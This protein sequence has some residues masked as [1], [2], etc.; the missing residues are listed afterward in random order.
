MWGR[1][2]R[3]VAVTAR[4]IAA[5]GLV[6]A[7]V[8]AA[9]ARAASL[10]SGGVASVTVTGPTT[11]SVTGTVNPGG[12]TTSY[13]VVYGL[14][15]SQWCQT[16][17]ASGQP[18]YS[19]GGG[20]TTGT[21]LHVFVVT[22]SGLT[23]GSTYCVA[24]R[25]TNSLGTVTGTPYRRFTAGAP[26]ARAYSPT[27]TSATTAT[28]YGGVNPAGQTT[29]YQVRYDL[30]GSTWCTSNGASGTATYSTVPQTLAYTDGTLHSVWVTM[31]G[32]TSGTGYCATI[33]A[34]NATASTTGSILTFTLD[35]PGV[36][37]NNV[38]V[39]GATTATITG[40]VNAFSQTN[41]YYRAI[42]DL[43]SSLWC[44][45]GGNVPDATT[46]WGGGIAFPYSDS[47]FHSVSVDLG[48][49]TAGTAY[50]ATL[51]AGTTQAVPIYFTTAPS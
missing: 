13:A 7:F 48:A 5:V 19:G 46:S 42:Y 17:G 43:A 3:A 12:L 4:S 21:S 20:V 30:A 16:Y 8:F 36:V 11:A 23:R 22:L 45:S 41:L 31:N 32:L 2:K 6:G 49:F 38:T 26:D 18:A 15:S 9:P 14:A 47:A 44:T 37:D 27:S 51:A 34:T 35:V 50:C 29:T 10:P 24:I 33:T 39:T 25:A 28:I 40:A 1:Q